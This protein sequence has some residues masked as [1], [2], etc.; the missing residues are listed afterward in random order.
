MIMI[1]LHKNYIYEAIKVTSSIVN[2]C[3]NLIE[4][5]K[6]FDF[7][8][9]DYNIPIYSGIVEY[10]KNNID[11]V[12]YFSPD[13]F[14]PAI[15]IIERR[16]NQE[17][18]ILKDRKY[19]IPFT[20]NISKKPEVFNSWLS[21]LR[22]TTYHELLHA[23]DPKIENNE[24]YFNKKWGVFEKYIPSNKGLEKYRNQTHERGVILS[25]IAKHIVEENGEEFLRNNVKDTTFIENNL[26]FG[27]N[28]VENKREFSKLLYFYFNERFN[29]A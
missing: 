17:G 13:I 12:S 16:E 21:L 22:E 7:S 29:N 10:N 6:N 25:A 14:K 8:H 1:I 3:D 20:E 24:L 9:L 27:M 28:S 15:Y 19:L 23:I 18:F 5:I 11:V 4:I 2:Y 26:P